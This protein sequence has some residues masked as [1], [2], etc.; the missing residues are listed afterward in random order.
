[1]IA[2]TFICTLEH[3]LHARP[4]SELAA[5]LRPFTAIARLRR[6]DQAAA[7]APVMSDDDHADARSVLSVVAL[8]IQ[9]DEHFTL[10]IDGADEADAIVAAARTLGR[11]LGE[12]GEIGSA[13]PIAADV[14]AVLK[15][16]GARVTRGRAVV[17]GV[18]IGRAVLL[19]AGSLKARAEAAASRGVDIERGSLN[20]AV[21]RVVALLRH[22]AQSAEG[23]RAEIANAHAEIV[24]DPALLGECER[25]I[26]AG[27]A[28][29]AAVVEASRLLQSKLSAATGEYARERALDVAD[30]RD[31]LLEQLLP[32]AGAVVQIPPDSVVVAHELTPG[33]LTR[34][35]T[36]NVRALVLGAVGASS[37]TVIVA[38]AMG[39]P[40]LVDVAGLDD[41]AG[42]SVGVRPGS[43]IIVDADAGFAVVDATPAVERLYAIQGQVRAELAAAARPTP[44]TEPA[45]PREPVTTRDGFRI[46]IGVNAA[47]VA[48]IQSGI[49]RGAEG[50]GL[51]RT[52]LLF[53]DRRTPPTEQEQADA[54]ECAVRAAAG[55]PVIIRL[56]DIGGD[57]PAPY[58][59]LPREENPFLG[60]R[61]VRVY[62]KFAELI[63]AQVRAALRAGASALPAASGAVSAPVPAPVKIMTPMVATVEEARW[64]ADLVAQERAAL[65]SAGVAVPAGLPVGVMVETPAAC[66]IIDLLAHHVS[67]ISFGTN[68]LAQ[69][70]AAADRGNSNVA[71]L[72]D[73]ASPAL[74]RAIRRAARA[75]KAAGLWVGVCGE[76]AADEALAPLLV[77]AGVNELSVTASVVGEVARRVRQLDAAACRTLLDHACACSTAV[78]VRRLMRSDAADAAIGSGDRRL[79][80]T[81]GAGTA[82]VLDPRVVGLDSPARTKAEA[83]RELSVRLVESGR[84]ESVRALEGAFWARESQFS[85]GVG[86]GAAIPHCRGPFVRDATIAVLRTRDSIAWNTADAGKAANTSGGP[87]S[88]SAF[89]EQAEP[90]DHDRD[91]VRLIVAL[92]VPGPAQTTAGSAPPTGRSAA[93]N[94]GIEHLR[95]LASVARK[96]VHD[97]FRDKLLRAATPQQ[98][99]DILRSELSLDPLP[100]AGRPAAGS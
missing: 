80:G 23:V 8:S 96:L 43:T 52:E 24:T 61:G 87:G 18:G 66:E 28:A 64:V 30:V 56:L 20:E 99:I 69:Y 12:R 78:E 19:Q 92:V 63:R 47:T 25:L 72:L 71:S 13:E 55:R 17:K 45:A 76:M 83:I 40:T 59:R 37:H 14:P 22:E 48:E 15:R 90:P 84:G 82:A 77:G 44:A 74:L 33:A 2:R 97:E 36:S 50:V 3:G 98:V 6:G 7:G 42:A 73:P 21:A 57:K 38:R 81:P 26:S 1:M 65:A 11:L 32:S 16:L 70:V 35:E 93:A 27:R 62:P 60:F 53:L 5:S 85:T 95:L 39:V 34:L 49:T 54:Y 46:E 10:E 94:A 88:P 68:D 100:G 51:L 41:A 86:E 29:P 58:L 67:F 4:A 91:L 31:R 89:A 79:A 9:P 75:A